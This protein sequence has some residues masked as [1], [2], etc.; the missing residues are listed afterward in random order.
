MSPEK[1]AGLPPPREPPG[2]PVLTGSMRPDECADLLSLVSGVKRP[3][4]D[5]VA[6]FLTRIPPERRLRFG[7]A[8]NFVLKDKNMLRP[9]E[10]L[11]A[12]AILRQV[13]SSQ[14]ENPFIPLLIHAA[15]D[16]TSDK[17]EWVFLQLLLNSTN[18]D[19]NREILRHSAA[20]YLEE[21]A[22]ASQVLLTREQLER[23]Y[24]CKEVQPQ[25]CT[26]SFRAATVRSAIPD[27]DVSQSCT[28]S[29][30]IS[31]AKSNRD[32]LI[33][34]LLQQT[35]LN[36]IGP[37]W[38][39][40]P[41]PRLEILERELQWLNLD[42]NHEL[43]WDSSMCAD[44]SRGAAIRDLVGKACKG[45]LSPAQQETCID[46]PVSRFSGKTYFRRRRKGGEKPAQP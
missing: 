39:R 33:T 1:D 34:S 36:G 45:P 41:P 22:Y 29:S 8:I 9:A 12:F 37:Q 23:R 38:I 42:N 46:P 17:P 6:D 19:N 21:S 11:I 28:D 2:V 13:Y 10:R 35:S 40:P 25:P 18:G 27:P 31:L 20:D 7:A 16:E 14:L 30:E 43:L 24:A 44:T 15:C 26:G 4:E 32:N 5:V 3:L